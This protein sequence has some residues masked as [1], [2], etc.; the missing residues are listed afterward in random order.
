MP[1]ASMAPEKPPKGIVSIARKFFSIERS[2]LRQVDFR[3][4]DYRRLDWQL[5]ILVADDHC[6]RSQLLAR[7]PRQGSF[8]SRQLVAVTTASA[9]PGLGSRR[10]QDV[11][12][13]ICDN[14][15]YLLANLTMMFHQVPAGG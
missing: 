1:I 14:A 7:K 11:R 8:R 15:N 5:R 12:A 2:C 3:R 4:N 9:T 13:D 6:W 10:R